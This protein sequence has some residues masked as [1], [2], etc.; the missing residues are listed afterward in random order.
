MDCLLIGS[1]E[2]ECNVE[3]AKGAVQS[4]AFIVHAHNK[5]DLFAVGTLWG[6]A[7]CLM[8]TQSTA[9]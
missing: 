1:L 8:I 2:T 4:V 5:A 6:A 3:Y 9:F 7:A